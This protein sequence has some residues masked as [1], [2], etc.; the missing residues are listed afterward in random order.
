MAM[1]WM[2]L[3][4]KMASQYSVVRKNKNAEYWEREFACVFFLEK[5][6]KRLTDSAVLRYN[7]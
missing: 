3:L 5:Q 7:A 6:E 2:C 1:F 4:V